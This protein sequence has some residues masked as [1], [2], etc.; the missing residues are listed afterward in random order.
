MKTKKKKPT[1]KRILPVVKRILPILLLLGVFG[2]LVSGAAEIAK[3]KK[4]ELINPR[5]I[6]WK[7]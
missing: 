7:N 5:K 3:A 6:S 1:K 2:S 4:N